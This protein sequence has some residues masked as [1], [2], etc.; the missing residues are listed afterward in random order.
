MGM[1][2]GSESRSMPVPV[3]VTIRGSDG[4]VLLGALEVV[5]APGLLGALE[6]SGELGPLTTVDVAGA[7]GPLVIR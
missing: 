4:L 3:S 6:V 1:R 7:S 2:G 5:T